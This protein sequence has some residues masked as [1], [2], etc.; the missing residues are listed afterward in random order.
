MVTIDQSI[1]IRY[2]LEGYLAFYPELRCLDFHS[3]SCTTLK[4]SE[5]A[6]MAFADLLKDEKVWARWDPILKTTVE[7]RNSMLLNAWMTQQDEFI[8]TVTKWRDTSAD[9][10]D[11]S[12]AERKLVESLHDVMK[13]WDFLGTLSAEN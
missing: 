7:E 6:N 12:P 2:F 11:L 5:Y 13:K 3:N 10:S 8:N 9:I 1:T 4:V